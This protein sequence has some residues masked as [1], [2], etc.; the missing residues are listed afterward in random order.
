MTVCAHLSVTLT[1]THPGVRVRTHR[2]AGPFWT[3]V[4]AEL[5]M[6]GSH[7]L[8]GARPRRGDA[9]TSRALSRLHRQSSGED[10]QSMLEDR[11][12]RPGAVGD[13]HGD[14]QGA[15][16]LPPMSEGEL[17]IS[18]V[19]VRTQP[20]FFGSSIQAKGSA[21]YAKNCAFPVQCAGRLTRRLCMA[22]A[23]VHPW[24]GTVSE[25]PDPI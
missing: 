12:T 3:A 17:D 5:R 9:R 2:R 20:Q 14:R 4:S 15:L 6:S 24:C 8:T 11:Q 18:T 7:M 16:K 22:G 13:R 21:H 10:T 25:K 19:P 1:E 23:P